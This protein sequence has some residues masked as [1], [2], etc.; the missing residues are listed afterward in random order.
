MTRAEYMRRRAVLRNA[1]HNVAN[2]EA[3]R[4]YG[5]GQ[6]ALQHALREFEAARRAMPKPNEDPTRLSW[7]QCMRDRRH[8]VV[9]SVKR[10]RQAEAL[11]PEV[12]GDPR[13]ERRLTQSIAYHRR[14]VRAY[15]KPLEARCGNV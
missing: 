6:P 8:C 4:A 14:V 1:C 11:W 5:Y 2:A 15:M 10:L 7:W 13:A 9:R 3:D 12:E